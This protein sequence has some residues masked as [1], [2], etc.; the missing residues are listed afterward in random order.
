MPKQPQTTPPS[1]AVPTLLECAELSDEKANELEEQHVHAVYNNIASHFSHTRYKAWPKVAEFASKIPKGSLVAD[2][3]CGNGK[4]L[5]LT[6]DSVYIGCDVSENLIDICGDRGFE[7]MVCNNQVLPYLP[8][9]FDFVLSI[10][11]IHHFSTDDRRTRAIQELLRIVRTGGRVLIYAWAIEQKKKYPGQDNLIP[12]NMQKCHI[13]NPDQLQEPAESDD[14]HV[15]YR[16]YYHL[17][18]EGELEGL[19]E[20]IEGC[21]IV[22]SYFDHE[23]WVVILEKLGS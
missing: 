17:F 9:S 12:W 15:I 4:N 2:I 1:A 10:A 14:R 23:N 21:K 19:C 11:V 6:N 8:N 13:T 18:K 16:R 3:G 22:E 7:C 5:G 20:S